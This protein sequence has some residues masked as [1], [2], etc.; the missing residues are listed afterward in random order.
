MADTRLDPSLERRKF[1]ALLGAAGA[2]VP[3]TLVGL[4]NATP[5][6]AQVLASSG[7]VSETSVP[8]TSSASA[9][10]VLPSSSAPSSSESAGS[11]GS[12]GSSESSGGATTLYA[13]ADTFIRRDSQ[14]TNEGANPYIRVGVDP[15]SRGLVQFDRNMLYSNLFPGARVRLV[16]RIANNHNEWGQYDDRTVSVHPLFEDFVG[17]NGAQ[18]GMPGSLQHRG[19]GAGATWNSPND[20]NVFDNA[21]RGATRLWNGGDR[22]GRRTAPRVVHVNQVQGVDVVWDVTSDV[23]SAGGALVAGWMIRVDRE[24]DGDDE[25][26]GGKL[27]VGFDRG[28]GGTVEY[29]SSEGANAAG[30]FTLGPR[31]VIS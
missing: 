7:S 26:P 12:S 5:A 25:H 19:T 6:Y 1:L 18:S 17:G 11:A 14:N 30:D 20:P 23:T 22:V 29:L 28:F 27:A 13:V 16:L 24:P 2:Y 3:P 10:S 8:G 9:P 21:A 4:L 15:V 31:L